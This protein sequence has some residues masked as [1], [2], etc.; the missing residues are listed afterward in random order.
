MDPYHESL[1][2]NHQAKF[3]EM[4][5]KIVLSWA[6]NRKPLSKNGGMHQVK[7]QTYVLI[8]VVF[9]IIVA[10]FAILNVAP[11]EVNY[12]FWT[13]KSPL[14]LVILFSVL[15]GVLITT[16]A[17]LVKIFQLQRQLKASKE[18]NHK[19]RMLL[20]QNGIEDVEAIDK[21]NGSTE[22]D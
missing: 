15:M 22:Q 11:V 12:L 1:L 14:I 21:Q 3:K 8:A 17:G 16:A 13:G 20:E 5:E 9:V 4:V 6:F 7:G 2:G 10:V 18:E 19:L